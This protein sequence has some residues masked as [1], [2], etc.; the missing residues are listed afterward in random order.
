MD[1]AVVLLLVSVVGMLGVALPGA[2][3]RQRSRQLRPSVRALRQAVPPG[4][5][6]VV[7]GLE[8]DTW[9]A[10]VA[11]T[12]GVTASMAVATLWISTSAAL[13]FAALTA[14]VWVART[15]LRA[16]LAL[17]AEVDLSARCEAPVAFGPRAG[18]DPYPTGDA[19]FDAAV[20]LTGAS[21][22]VV[23]TY[24]DVATR[25]AVGRL[26]DAGGTL[27]H[28][29]LRL[30]RRI[31]A[32]PSDA[33]ALGRTFA[34]VARRLQ[35]RRSPDVL[36]QRVLSDPDPGVRVRTLRAL[37]QRGWHDV[38]LEVHAALLE[39]HPRAVL[40][41]DPATDHALLEGLAR[42]G[43]LADVARLRAYAD[44]VD[45]DLQRRALAALAAIRDRLGDLGQGGLSVAPD[46][47]HLTQVA[48]PGA[49][50]PL[51]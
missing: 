30:V 37:E 34:D 21:P 26:S 25:G 24:M 19:A 28:G 11:V 17:F 9:S 49:R 14:A 46:R 1:V 47:G 32:D 27:E 22:T 15:W 12:A 29:T 31:P 35:R 41:D 39:A 42:G 20:R 44:E 51:S 3:T 8:G 38:L 33:E 40:G 48:E 2:I 50:R 18:G 6:V 5:E 7:D 23:P 43:T 10:A 13:S 36:L 4:T 45:G 16:Y